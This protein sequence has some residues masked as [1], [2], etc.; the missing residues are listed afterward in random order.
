MTNEESV[1][2][3]IAALVRPVVEYPSVDHEDARE[4]CRRVSEL[5]KAWETTK[6]QTDACNVCGGTH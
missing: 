2:K 1:L 3:Q 5:V 6:Q 4:V